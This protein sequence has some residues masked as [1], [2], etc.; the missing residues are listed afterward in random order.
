M[1]VLGPIWF[2]EGSLVESQVA[3]WNYVIVLHEVYDL[4]D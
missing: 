1:R 2:L 4:E 3:N